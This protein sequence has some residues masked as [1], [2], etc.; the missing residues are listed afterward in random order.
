MK[1]LI[2]KREKKMASA[3]MPYWVVTGMSRQEFIYK[4]HIQEDRY[5]LRDTGHRYQSGDTVTSITI[6]SLDAIGVKLENGRTVTTEVDDSVRAVF[7]CTSGGWVT[8]E[9]PLDKY[10]KPDGTYELCISTKG[11][12]T[13]SSYPY[14]K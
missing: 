7:A 5:R 11:G 10:L 14:F 9:V 2:I 1:K 8:E 13:E 6:H 4:F 12:L 3:L